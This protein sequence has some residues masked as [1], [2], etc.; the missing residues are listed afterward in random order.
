M[1]GT[2]NQTPTANRVHIGFFGRRNA[3]KSSLV[4]AV[5]GQDLAIVSDVKGT[6]TDPVL[7][8]ME[9]LPVGPVVI[10]DTPGLDDEGEVGLLRVKKARQV[11]N[12]TDVA[13]LVVDA[14]Q[15]L[16]AEDRDLITLFRAKAL[17]YLIVYNKADLAQPEVL[18]NESMAVSAL[19]GDGITALKERIAAL[20]K[21]EDNGRRILGDLLSPEDIVIL[22]TPIDASAPKGRMILPQVQS[23]RDILDSHA[24]CFVTQVEQLPG[25]L[26]ALKA[27]PRMVVTDSQVFG[28]VKSMVPGVVQPA[29][30]LATPSSHLWPVLATAT[31]KLWVVE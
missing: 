28:K 22:V 10:I 20:A 6:T 17:P 26:N 2:M 21:R 7:K 3:G 1:A 11:L 18:D 14:A 16:S 9:L 12:K 8:A 13:I 31:S 15:G 5:T 29:A 4:N 25:V 30:G 19:T 23:I 24:T 27:P